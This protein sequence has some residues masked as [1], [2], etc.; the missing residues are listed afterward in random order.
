MKVCMYIPVKQGFG[1]AERRYARLVNYLN[2]V[3]SEVEIHVL[4]H[5]HESLCKTFV[6][7]YL[8]DLD[9]SHI[10]IAQK[11]HSAIRIVRKLSPDI[12]H[13]ITVS[14]SSA[15]FYLSVLP[16][17][18]KNVLALNS[19]YLA[20]GIYSSFL[21]EKI[22][23]FIL[24]YTDVV[25]LLYPSLASEFSL[26]TGFTNN[27][28]CKNLYVQPMPFTN[29]EQF[30]P[31]K[32]KK[33]LIVF[34]GRL[35][36]FKNP[37]ILLKASCLSKEILRK[38]GYKVIIC[39]IGEE[40]KNLKHFVKRVGISDIIKFTE[41]IDAEK[42]LNISKIFIS[43]QSIE[44]YP[45]QSLLEA[46]SSGNYIIASNV[47]DTNLIVK[48]EFGTLIDLST[49]ALSIAIEKAVSKDDKEYEVITARARSFAL[50]KFKIEKSAEHIVNIWRKLS[51]APLKN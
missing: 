5:G 19:Y 23:K 15:L 4:L 22:F 24:N 28:C 36:R 10:H 42:I 12:F 21:Q 45:S 29:L 35:K 51:T 25:D 43:I 47:G 46:I 1:G 17:N 33:N 18:K 8:W 34:V 41:Y 38:Y 6:K 20:K 27:S 2:K 30:K 50:K 13:M 48:P 14:Q 7:K 11:N 9:I 49:E 3:V 37:Q 39:G 26:K 32:N 16:K 40:L 31:K 44:N